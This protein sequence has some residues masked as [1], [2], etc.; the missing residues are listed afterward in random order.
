MALTYTHMYSGDD[1]LTHF[2]E[3]EL[4][5]KKDNKSFRISSDVLPATGVFFRATDVPQAF[6]IIGR[7]FAFDGF[8]PIETVLKHPFE[9]ACVLFVHGRTLWFRLPIPERIHRTRRR[10][11]VYTEPLELATLLVIAVFLRGPGH[12]F[13]YFQF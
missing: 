11:R 12:N 7:M 3:V 4:N 13:V 8:D 9:V 10:I 5:G 6:S 2:K 1:G